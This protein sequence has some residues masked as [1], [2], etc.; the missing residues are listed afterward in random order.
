MS[1]IKI[2]PKELRDFIRKKKCN[3]PQNIYLAKHLFNDVDHP[4]AKKSKDEF[5]IRDLLDYIDFDD[6]DTIR[7]HKGSTE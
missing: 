6:T 5:R 4:L 3:T 7:S 1:R 2:T